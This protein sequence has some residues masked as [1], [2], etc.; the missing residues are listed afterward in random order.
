[1]SAQGHP[2]VRRPARRNERSISF[3]PRQATNFQTNCNEAKKGRTLDGMECRIE[4][5]VFG[6]DR[7]ERET[8][9]SPRQASTRKVTSLGLAYMCIGGIL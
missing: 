5:T 9:G 4:A 1:M 3:E 6:G 7:G 2:V 8:A